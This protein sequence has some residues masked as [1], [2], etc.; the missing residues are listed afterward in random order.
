MTRRLASEALGTA[1]LLAAIVGS[2]IM[3][4][5]LAGGNVAIA[6]LANSIA[7]GAVLFVLITVLGPVSGAHFNPVVTASQAVTSGIGWRA[8]VAYGGAQ[9]AGAIAGVMVA[10]AMFDTPWLSSSAHAR[11]GWPQMLS[12]FIATFGL[13]LVIA[14]VVQQRSERAATAVAAYIVSA[15]WF[16]A[17]TSFANPAVTVARALT[18]TF[19]G[20]RLADVAPFIAAQVAGGALATVVSLWLFAPYRDTVAAAVPTRSAP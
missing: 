4:D 17:S 6:L 3:G 1:C 20:I 11:S 7:T 2:G 16:T 19:A 18:D 9:L 12:E 8:A 10:H 15:S 14:G 13:V 5:R